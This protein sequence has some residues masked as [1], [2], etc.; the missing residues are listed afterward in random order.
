MVQ[1]VRRLPGPPRSRTEVGRTGR[2]PAVS[3]AA[4][5]GRKLLPGDARLR[6]GAARG[7]MKGQTPGLNPEC[8]GAPPR[9]PGSVSDRPM[10]ERMSMRKG[11]CTLGEVSQRGT[12]STRNRIAGSSATPAAKAK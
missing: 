11:L 7:D 6:T 12:F 5:R 3:R 9:R 2:G 1:W 4:L 10:R 8:S